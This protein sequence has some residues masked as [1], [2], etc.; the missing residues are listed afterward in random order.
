MNTQLPNKDEYFRTLHRKL[1]QK[2]LL[3]SDA[4]FYLREQVINQHKQRYQI[5]ADLGQSITKKED[6]IKKVDVTTL[7]RNKQLKYDFNRTIMNHHA[8]KHLLNW[9]THCT[10]VE[11]KDITQITPFDDEEE[12][13][14]KP[15]KL[16]DT[17]IN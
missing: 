6:Q 2:Y 1:A 8:E 9:I 16:F 14:Q 11:W 10:D 12:Y 17:P 15:D 5:I 7:D 4:V 3:G 13:S